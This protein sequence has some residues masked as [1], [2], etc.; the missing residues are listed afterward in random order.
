[1]GVGNDFCPEKAL[2]KIPGGKRCENCLEYNRDAKS[3]SRDNDECPRVH[4]KFYSRDDK[5]QFLFFD[6]FA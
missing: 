3:R 2:V 6:L 4:T 5:L 1:V